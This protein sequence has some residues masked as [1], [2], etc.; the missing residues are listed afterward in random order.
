MSTISHIRKQ[1]VAMLEKEDII[2]AP[3]CFDVLSARIIEATGHDCVYMTGFGTCASLLGLPDMGFISMP[4]I[5][6]NAR[7]VAG[8]VNIP[9]IADADTGYGN[10]LNVYRTV[11]EYERSGVAAIHIE[12]QTF[13]K[14]CGHLEGKE[15]VAAEE[16]VEKIK[17]ACD[18]RTDQDFKIIVRTDSRAVNGLDDAITRARKYH[19][20]GA[21]II[22]VESPYTVD[23]FEY[24]A[25]ELKGIPLL[26]NMAEGGKS[27]MLSSSELKQM[28]YKIVIYPVGL[29]F[30]AS[31]AMFAL[32]QE[33]KEK[34]T[35][36]EAADSMWT[37]KQFTDFIGVPE[38]NA[39]SEKYRSN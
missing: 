32:S 4:E 11:K 5:I 1:F 31:K 6:D 26:A 25:K 8:A 18:A 10:P 16:M 24:I 3:G 22:F 33:I 21:D 17:A 35:D 34:G 14:R 27:P 23:E 7:R 29:L 12:D 28:G 13:P 37:F 15:V 19:E 39:L 2:E 30:A 36:R 9:V 20:A 38:Y